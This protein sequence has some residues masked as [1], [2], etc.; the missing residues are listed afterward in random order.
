MSKKFYEEYFLTGMHHIV[1]Q[2]SDVRFPI[3]KKDMIDQ[4]G[5]RSVA[6]DFDK[7]VQMRSLIEPIALDEFVSSAAFYN[8]L[9][10][11]L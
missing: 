5:N 10:A 3:T 7:S 11:S 8:A 9:V 6:T 2:A 4:I 1:K